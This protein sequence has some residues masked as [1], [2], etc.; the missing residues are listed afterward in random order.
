MLELGC[1]LQSRRR[2]LSDLPEK[3]GQTAKGGDEQEE[4]EEEDDVGAEGA[5]EE[6]QAQH[7]HVELEV[8]EGGREDGVAARGEGLGGRVGNRG[9]VVGRQRRAEGEPEGAEGAEDDE[10]EGVAE[11]ELE[12]GAKDHEQAAEEVVDTAARMLEAAQS[13]LVGKTYTSAAPKPPAP[14]QPRRTLE[15]GVRDSKKPAR[16]LRSPLVIVL[17]CSGIVFRDLQG[18]W[19]TKGRPDVVR[20]SVLWREVDLLEELRRDRQAAGCS[21]SSKRSIFIMCVVMQIVLLLPIH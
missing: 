12:E 4:D 10:G 14:L 9:V 2:R 18:C 7:A 16:A 5:D 8:G 1:L 11:D 13:G 17:T 3:A 21:Q 20:D 6:D 15:R 19:I